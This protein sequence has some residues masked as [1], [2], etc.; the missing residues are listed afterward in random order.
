MIG[1]VLV[2]TA[3]LLVSRLSSGEKEDEN[4]K[5]FHMRNKDYEEEL[6]KGEL[7]SQM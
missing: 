7:D 3:R 6:E 5:E 1:E 4:E 2:S